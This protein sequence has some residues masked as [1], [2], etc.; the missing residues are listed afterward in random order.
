MSSHKLSEYF[1]A[2]KTSL[3]ACCVFLLPLPYLFGNLIVLNYADMYMYIKKACEIGTASI[4]P[5]VVHDRTALFPFTLHLLFEVFG[6]SLYSIKVFHIFLLSVLCVQSWM[7]CR[8]LTGNNSGVISSVFIATSFVFGHFAYFPHIDLLLTVCL[9]F[10]LLVLYEAVR[11]RKDQFKWI[12]SSGLLLGLTYALKQ[13]AI[14]LVALLPLYLV[15]LERASLPRI[16]KLWGIQLLGLSVF[17]VPITILSYPNS[18]G[19]VWIMAKNIHQPLGQ[20]QIP[21]PLSLTRTLTYYFDPILWQWDMPYNVVMVRVD[22]I[23]AL[24]SFILFLC[25]SNVER[26]AKGFVFL[27]VLIFLPWYVFVA[28]KGWKLRQ[29]LFPEFLIFLTIGPLIHYLFIGK[30]KP[31]ISRNNWLRV[32]VGL[33]LLLC[34][35]YGLRIYSIDRTIQKNVTEARTRGYQRRDPLIG[36]ARW[37]SRLNIPAFKGRQPPRPLVTR[38]VIPTVLVMP[39]ALGFGSISESQLQL[40]LLRK[41]SRDTTRR[42]S[43]SLPLG[44]GLKIEKVELEKSLFKVVT[45]EIRPGVIVQLLVEPILEKLQKGLNEDRLKIHTNQKGY[46]VLEVPISLE[47]LQEDKDYD[48][49]KDIFGIEDLFEDEWLLD[50]GKDIFGGYELFED[51]PFLKGENIFGDKG[52]GDDED[53]DNDEAEK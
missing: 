23:A 41:N 44:D 49:G 6:Y 15:L 17:L 8:M 20:C 18:F 32:A 7:I 24:L 35:I 39:K 34:A 16:L 26:K 29:L 3:L 38:N 22:Q 25:W 37:P 42:V 19:Y 10:C 11:A 40:Q 43:V 47:I 45:R 48:E 13:T 36:Y 9:N 14:V 4:D 33:G 52:W 51:E 21:P 27:A 30:I 53:R 12:F 46:E 28:Y 2:W 31:R 5:I 1:P 50:E